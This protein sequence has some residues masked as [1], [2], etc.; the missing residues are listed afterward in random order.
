M[1]SLRVLC[2]DVEGGYG[3]SS[4][5]LWEAL[6]HIDRSRIEAEVWCRK[7]GPA[8]DRYRADDIPVHVMSDMPTVSALPKPSRNLVV[9]ARF[10]L[11][12]WP[13][14]TGFRRQLLQVLKQRFDLVHCNHESLFALASWM[15]PRVSLPITGHVRTNLW[16]SPLA[17]LQVSKFAAATDSL[18][19]ITENE[20]RTFET[21]LGSSADGA[22]IYNPVTLPQTTPEPLADFATDSRYRIACL[23]NYS[24][25]R[26]VDRLVDLAAALAAQGRRDVLFIVA[27]NMNLPRSLPGVLGQIARWGGSLT[28]YA[29]ARGVSDMF[30]FLGHVDAPERVLATADALIKPT[31]EANPWGRDIIEALAAARPVIA[32]GRWTGFV[33]PGETGIL[34]EVFDAQMM[35][36]EVGALADDRARSRAMGESGRARIANLCDPHG[37]AVELADFWGRVR[38]NA[39]G[40]Y[41]RDPTR[42]GRTRRSRS[43]RTVTGISANPP[44]H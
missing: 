21:H 36:A 9:F 35:A 15:R 8:Q 29:A 13:R 24:W 27:G 41:P 44:V 19:F 5:S 34:Q 25:N 17:R 11:S 32:V 16:P 20:R 37:R 28:D 2:L 23:S 38:T 26:G 39:A 42:R 10:L 4:R 31:R 33:S 3:G 43:V 1:T 18:V 6:R 40:F 7:H 12:D 22:V 30:V 14:A